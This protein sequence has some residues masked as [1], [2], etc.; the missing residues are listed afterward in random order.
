MDTLFV[1]VDYRYV[2]VNT[3]DIC[4]IKGYGEYLQLFIRETSS[5]LLTL[6]SF[7]SIKEKLPSNFL[8]VHRSYLVNM[9]AIQSISKGRI[10]MP[11]DVYIPV[12]D[13]YKDRFME[14]LAMHSIGV[15]QKK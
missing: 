13:I 9:N 5:P 15:S 1:K 2:R 8:Q 7:S 11:P 3:S 10:V 4:Y 14:Y 6:S 12:G